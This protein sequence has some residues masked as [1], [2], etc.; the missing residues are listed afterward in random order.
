[1]T[2]AYNGVKPLPLF[3]PIGLDHLPYSRECGTLKRSAMRDLLSFASMRLNFSSVSPS[4][5][6]EGVRRLATVI[7]TTS[8]M[9]LA[10]QNRG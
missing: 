7:V 8:P 1:V 9:L 3:S 6:C 2:H 4:A 5:L 10:N